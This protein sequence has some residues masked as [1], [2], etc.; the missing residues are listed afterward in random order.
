MKSCSQTKY[1]KDGYHTCKLKSRISCRLDLTVIVLAHDTR[2]RGGWIEGCPDRSEMP[3]TQK[4]ISYP[5]NRLFVTERES[6]H[7]EIERE[8]ASVC[9][10][11]CVCL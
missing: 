10:R 11:V 2:G 5:S 7:E 9:V 4:E 6:M 1:A 8:R 3:S